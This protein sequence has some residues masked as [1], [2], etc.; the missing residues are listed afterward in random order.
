MSNENQQQKT[1][2]FVVGTLKGK[3]EKP[4]RN[5]SDFVDMFLAVVTGS[6]QNEYDETVENVEKINLSS[7]QYRDIGDAL[8]GRVVSVC[9]GE[10]VQY[11]LTKQAKT[12]YGFLRRWMLKGTMPQAVPAK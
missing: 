2:V 4:Q 10:K 7:E 1:G 11:G 6:Y 5:N 9:C 8:V 3:F 12:P